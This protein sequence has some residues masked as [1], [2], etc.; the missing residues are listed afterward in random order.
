VI[1]L[2]GSATTTVEA[3]TSFVDPGATAH[4]DKGP[5]PI[6]VTGSVDVNVP[7]SYTVSYTAHNTYATT[8][9][10][11]TVIVSDTIAPSITGFIV[12]PD[13]Y[14]ARNHLMFDVS[15][16]YTATDASRTSICS[17]TATRRAIG[18]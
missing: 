15:V 13:T 4:D 3:F 12:A 17:A 5:L 1:A 8:T 6:T 16:A 7:G 10:T 18:R 2:N 11:R 14:Q 9:V